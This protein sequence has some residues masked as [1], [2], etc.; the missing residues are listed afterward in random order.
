MECLH[1]GECCKKM[2]PVSD[3]PCPHL[4]QEGN[5]FLCSTY[6]DRP[7][8]CKKHEYPFRFCPVG[9]DVLRISSP[10]EVAFRLDAGYALNKY[11]GC[12]AH[13][14]LDHLLREAL[15]GS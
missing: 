5:F 10:A 8:A 7:E 14:A 11:P 15:T 9:L 6:P 4:R 3:K 1:C 12:S 2:S 13:E